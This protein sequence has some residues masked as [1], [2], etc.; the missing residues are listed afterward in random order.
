M[1]IFASYSSFVGFLFV[2]SHSSLQ[3]YILLRLINCTFFNIVCAFGEFV[4]I[5]KILV[6]GKAL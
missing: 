3:F 2:S 4:A 5:G 1:T 6:G